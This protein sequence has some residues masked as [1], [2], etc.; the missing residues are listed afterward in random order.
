MEFFT[1]RFIGFILS[2]C[3][4]KNYKMYALNGNAPISIS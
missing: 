2:E 4:K 3:F 1:R